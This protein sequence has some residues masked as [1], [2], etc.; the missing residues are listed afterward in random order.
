MDSLHC[1]L[2]AAI[3]IL[4][5]WVAISQLE[6]SSLS[7]E[8]KEYKDGKQKY[9]NQLTAVM[10]QLDSLVDESNKL[11]QL[12]VDQ[13]KAYDERMEFHSYEQMDFPRM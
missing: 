3:L 10:V 1:F 7:A 12:V 8:A 6:I 11:Q 4:S 5:I 2:M 9:H 13:K